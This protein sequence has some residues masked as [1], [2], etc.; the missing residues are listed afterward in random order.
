MD[1]SIAEYNNILEGMAHYMGQLL[2]LAKKAYYAVSG[3]FRPFLIFINT[4][5]KDIEETKIKQKFNITA[6]VE[7][8]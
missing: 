2:A 7:W 6:L 1:L 3:N 4:L 5:R 8:L